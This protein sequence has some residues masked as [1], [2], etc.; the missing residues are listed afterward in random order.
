[1]NGCHRVR[2]MI[3]AYA[4]RELTGEEMYHVR[5]HLSACPECQRE[6]DELVAVKRSLGAI[7]IPAAPDDLLPRLKAATTAEPTRPQW[8]RRGV[9]IGLSFA[10]SLMV[11]TFA[12]LEWWSV[13][14]HTPEP[15]SSPVQDSAFAAEDFGVQPRSI[16]VTLVS[17]PE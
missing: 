13:R 8:D 5:N 11:L 17:A 4:D 3:S 14:Q 15:I 2:L 16:P 7:A 12:I 9:T 10:I 1:M 6:Y